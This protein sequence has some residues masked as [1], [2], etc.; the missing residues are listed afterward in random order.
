MDAGT[1]FS[2]DDTLASVIPDL[3]QYDVAARAGA[4]ATFRQ[5]LATRRTFRASS[6]ST[7]M[8]RIPRPCGPSSCSGVWKSG[9]PVYSD[10]NFMLLGIAIERVTGRPLIEQPLP[11]SFTFRPDP[12]LCAATERCA[13]RGRVIRG[14]VHDENAFALGA[15]RAMPVCLERSTASSIS[16]NRFWTGAARPTSLEPSGPV[17]SETRTTRVGSQAQRLVGGRPMLRDDHRPHGLHR[18]GALDRFQARAGL[19]AA[20]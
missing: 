14:E 9:P 16:R 13:W 8:A 20:H 4:E 18:H 17:T 5:C 1:H 10:I 7:P 19:D 12:A 15:P 6:R 3:R 2:L 11:A